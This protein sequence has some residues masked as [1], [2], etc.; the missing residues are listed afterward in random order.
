MEKLE[1]LYLSEED[2]LGL[3]IS[4]E[5]VFG[6][7]E[8]A[9]KEH[10]EKTV[11]NPPKPGVHSLSNSFIHAM[12]AYLEQMQ[13]IGLKWV[14]GYPPN[15][16][17][18]LP[19]INGLQI[20]NCAQ[21]G[22]PLAVMN[23]TWTTTVRTAAVSAVTAMRCARKDSEVVGI[24]GAG[25]QGRINI[26]A[27]KKILPQIKKCKVY[28][29]F[30]AAS[31]GFREEISKKLDI[32]IEIVSSPEEAVRNSD[33][34][35]TATQKLPEPIVKYEWLKEGVLGLPLESSRAW[36][37]EALFGVDKFINDDLEQAKLYQSQGAFSGGIPELHAETGEVIAG[38]K[39][40]RE[41]DTEKIIAMNIGLACEDISFGKYIYEKAMEKGV[42]SK[43]QL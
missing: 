9:L 14:S 19:V 29:I 36:T 8:K 16:E 12:P 23:A 33:I 11:E 40:G 15:R 32:E 6:S 31:D 38:L 39:A 28:D 5:E 4:W 17:K 24:I 3:N 2:I 7:V 25:V 30:P 37:N 42:G 13:A 34:V 21:T 43:L 22:V 20:I 10:G 18:N 35:I 26:I 41:N 27:L 1:F